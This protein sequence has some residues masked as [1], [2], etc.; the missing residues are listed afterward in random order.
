MVPEVRAGWLYDFD[1]D[2]RTISASFAGAPGTSFSVRGQDVQRHGAL[3]G[4]G[5][6]FLHKGGLRVGLRY[7]AE[8]RQDYQAHGLSGGVRY[9]F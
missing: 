9:E 6:T 2:D 3:V 5:L 4:A 1:I 8:L 7:D